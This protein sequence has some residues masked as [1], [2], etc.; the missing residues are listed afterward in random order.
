MAE[1]LEK[2]INKKEETS[3]TTIKYFNLKKGGGP[4]KPKTEAEGES[5]AT[6]A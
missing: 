1:D 6:L 2:N 5:P 3:R 4:R